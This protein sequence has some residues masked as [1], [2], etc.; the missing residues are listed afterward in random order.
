MSLDS[1][2]LSHEQF[3]RYSRHLLMDDIGEAG[4]QKL[5]KSR[6]LIVGLGGLGCPV[7]LYL[8]AAGV[9]ELG[10]C[11]PDTVELSNL[12]RQVLYKEAD[13]GELKVSCAR[14]EL[15]ALNP[16]LQVSSYADKVSAEVLLNNY[17]IVVDCTDNLAARQLINQHCFK[18]KNA[19]VSASA[20]G[21][22]GQ[23]V[24]FDFAH[25]PN[26][27]L[28]CIID[29]DSSEP[30]LNCSNSGVVGPVL[31]AMGS[32]QATTVIRMLLGFFQQHGELQRYDGK[33]GRWLNLRTVAKPHCD[34][35][36]EE[37]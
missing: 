6:V 14:R 29:K 13:C 35:C 10:L 24:A 26:L 27:C 5:I 15:T 25:N 21:W 11:D 16:N 1:A 36:S 7:A 34:I 31:G 12:Q 30:L 20:L 23:L 9:G 4:Q 17:D 28:N 8:A 18:Q 2:N 32:L 37:T 33:T 19:F 3:M 22:E